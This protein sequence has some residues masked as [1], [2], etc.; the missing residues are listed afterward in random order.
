MLMATQAPSA[1]ALAHFD[2]AIRS[3]RGRSFLGYDQR[4]HALATAALHTLTYSALLLQ[5]CTVQ[6]TIHTLA[7][8]TLLLRVCTTHRAANLM[9]LCKLTHLCSTISTYNALFSGGLMRT[10]TTIDDDR[11][12]SS[13]TWPTSSTCS[14]SLCK[15]PFSL[16]QHA[17]LVCE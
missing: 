7:Y 16:S 15:R 12:T 4:T 14:W 6:F 17:C 11:D 10:A 13:M 5:V 8:L 1:A 2:K 9:V 3:V